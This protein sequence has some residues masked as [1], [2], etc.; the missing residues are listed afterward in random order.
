MIYFLKNQ[1]DANL[2]S[3]S[4]FIAF[5]NTPNLNGNK[6]SKCLDLLKIKL[7]NSPIS[8]LQ[9]FGTEGLSAMV[10]TLNK[11]NAKYDYIK[12]IAHRLFYIYTH[13]S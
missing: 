1:M 9:E 10:S 12:I 2:S 3:P 6:I 13:Q 11:S 4:E 7:N 5:L 8:W